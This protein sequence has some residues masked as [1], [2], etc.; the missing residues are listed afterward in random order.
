D[1]RVKPLIMIV[2]KWAKKHQINDAKDGTLS[3]Y[4]LSLMVINYLQCQ[5]VVVA[6][7]ADGKLAVYQTISLQKQDAVPHMITF[8]RTG[9]DATCQDCASHP[10]ACITQARKRLY[11]GCGNDVIVVQP[12]DGFAVERRW[13]VQDRNRGL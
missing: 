8:C 12:N 2:K 10:V 11:V 5:D 4:A 6:G 13:S 9:S 3:S 1:S 7:L